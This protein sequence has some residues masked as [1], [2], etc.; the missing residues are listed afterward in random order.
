MESSLQPSTDILNSQLYSQAAFMCSQD[1]LHSTTRTALPGCAR[2][3]P[4]PPPTAFLSDF[5][6]S[7][8]LWTLFFTAYANLL[9]SIKQNTTSV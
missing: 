1:G 3:G 9:Y 7:V 4:P 6:A 2:P 5:T 8:D